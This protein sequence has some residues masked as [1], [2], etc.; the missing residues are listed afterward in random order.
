MPHASGT[1]IPCRVPFFAPLPPLVSPLTYIWGEDGYTESVLSFRAAAS[2]LSH[3][4]RR[5]PSQSREADPSDPPLIITCLARHPLRSF[6]YASFFLSFSVGSFV[7]FC[8]V[9]LGAFCVRGVHCHC[10][11]PFLQRILEH[12][13]LSL[14]PRSHRW[15]TRTLG[16]LHR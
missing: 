14:L 11:C 6:R 7:G 9:L 2:L 15:R 1:C 8:L 3:A 10:H 4:L 16:Y 12:V 5:F 13:R